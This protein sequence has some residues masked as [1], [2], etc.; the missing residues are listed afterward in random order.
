MRMLTAFR[1]LFF[2]FCLVTAAAH[3]QLP[4]KQV[5]QQAQVWLSMNAHYRFNQHWG[6][7][8]DVHIRRNNFLKDPSFD[9]ARL[10]ASY[11]FNDQMAVAAGYGHLWTA[12]AKIEWNTWGNEHRIYQQFQYNGKL[13]KTGVSHRIRNEQRW[14]QV[15]VDDEYSGRF[16][17]SN[18]VRYQVSFGFPIFKNSKAPVLVLSDELLIQFGKELVYNTFDQNRLFIGIR[19][20]LSKNFSYDFGYMNVYQQRITGYQYDMNHT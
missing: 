2:V 1:M 12:P 9:F 19:Q 16:R 20:N 14:Q 13:G 6:I 8:G 4:A 10:G 18:R 17:F 15:I 5:R 7:I 3:G 11:W